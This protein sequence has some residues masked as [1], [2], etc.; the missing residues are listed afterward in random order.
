MTRLPD[1]SWIVCIYLLSRKGD[2]VIFLDLTIFLSRVL[3]TCMCIN[4][5]VENVKSDAVVPVQVQGFQVPPQDPGYV[6]KQN[7]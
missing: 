1:L 4:V 7:I 2:V 3:Y 6:C 5:Y